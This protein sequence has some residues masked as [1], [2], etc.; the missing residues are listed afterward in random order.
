M[1]K[2][3]RPP[4]RFRGVYEFEALD[5]VFCRSVCSIEDKDL[6]NKL[7]NSILVVGGG[8]KFDGFS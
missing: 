8:C 6:R 4:K 7:A 2:V 3:G 5:E 1:K